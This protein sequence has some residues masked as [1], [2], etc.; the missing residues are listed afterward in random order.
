VLEKSKH[1]VTKGNIACL[2]KECFG[3]SLSPALLTKSFEVCGI[4]PWNRKNVRYGKLVS[5]GLPAPEQVDISVYTES[6]ETPGPVP[7]PSGYK[8]AAG[9]EVSAMASLAAFLD[10]ETLELFEKSY[11]GNLLDTL[12]DKSTGLYEFWK[13]IKS[14][15]PTGPRWHTPLE[16]APEIAAVLTP[17]TAPKAATSETVRR[18]FYQHLSNPNYRIAKAKRAS[19]ARNEAIVEDEKSQS[20]SSSDSEIPPP[21]GSEVEPQLSQY[22]AVFFSD[23]KSEVP[24]FVGRILDFTDEAQSK[25]K[26]LKWIK[27]ADHTLKW[28]NVDDIYTVNN[29]EIF[30]GPLKL[31]GSGPFQIAFGD[32]IPVAYRQ[33]CEK[34]KS[35]V[36]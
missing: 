6:Q 12:D 17:P 19:K 4:Y 30:A 18:K 26:F 27:M 24:Y 23:K 3:P 2:L 22:Y 8:K 16:V 31:T 36:T 28:P 33:H 9:P 1:E 14:A 20:F 32:A 25:L 15:S 11:P 13:R 29:E 34:K 7:D 5:E 35:H 10:P 21:V